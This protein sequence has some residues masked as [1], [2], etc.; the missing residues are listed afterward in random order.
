MNLFIKVKDKYSPFIDSF[1]HKMFRRRLLFFLLILFILFTIINSKS[2][3][4]CSCCKGNG[5]IKR[6]QGSISMPTC[7]AKTCKHT[8]KLRYPGQCGASLGTLSATCTKT[9]NLI[10]H[11][12]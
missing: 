7:S 8:C 1:H 4:S 3:C 6:H 9:K 11:H 2:E 12:L 5:C 10:D